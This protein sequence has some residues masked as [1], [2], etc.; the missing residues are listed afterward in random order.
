M[1]FSEEAL[2]KF[3]WILSRYPNRSAAILPSLYL[4]QQEFGQISPE[5]ID[6]VSELLK[7]SPAHAWGVYSFYTYFKQVGMGK[8]IIRVCST[9]PCALC[10]SEKIFDYLKERLGIGNNQ[11]TPDKKFTLQKVECLASCDKGPVVQINETYYEKVTV[12]KIAHILDRL[13]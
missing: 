4:A 13:E 9:L 1:R 7:I 3:E 12:E 6:Y 11:T 10:E 5:V 8:Y 2:K